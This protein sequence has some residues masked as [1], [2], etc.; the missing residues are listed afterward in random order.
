MSA[1]TRPGSA[2]AVASSAA[3]IV[4]RTLMTT[5]RAELRP[6][7]DPAAGADCSAAASAR[8]REGGHTA[9]H[10]RSDPIADDKDGFFRRQ[11][12]LGMRV[13]VQPGRV[14]VGVANAIRRHE[15]Q[16]APGSSKR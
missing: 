5:P 7:L 2:R 10:R 13:I 14:D 1:L 12:R 9:V 6:G 8:D 3:A 4:S 16:Q 11:E 15:R